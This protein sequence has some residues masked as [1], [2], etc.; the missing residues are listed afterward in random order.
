MR[1]TGTT[2]WQPGSGRPGTSRTVESI[3][4]V[5]DLVL[6]Q[7]GAPGTHRTTHQITKELAFQWDASYTKTFS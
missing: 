5:D 7:E 4:T 6:S 3:D 1:E 2:D